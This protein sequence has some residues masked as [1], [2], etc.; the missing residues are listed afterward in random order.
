MLYV[1]VKVTE[2]C[3]F[4]CKYCYFFCSKDN[5]FLQ[6]PPFMDFDTV[7]CLANF[8]KQGVMDLKLKHIHICIHGGEP[9]LY[10]TDNID[11]FCS[12]ILDTISPYAEICFSIQTNGYL[13][14]DIWLDLFEKYNMFVGVS[15]DGPSEYHD[16]FR[17]DAVG[18]KTHPV[19]ENNLKKLLKRKRLYD[20]K[21]IGILTV[22]DPTHSPEKLYKY[23]VHKLEVQVMDF[24]L[25]DHHYDHKPPYLPESYGNFLIELYKQWMKDDD[26][27]IR[28]KFFEAVLASIL[29]YKSTLIG[30]GPFVPNR[31]PVIT[32]SSDGS[33]RAVDELCKAVPRLISKNVY[34][35]NITCK[36]F[37][38]SSV[39]K[40]I[41]DAQ[42][43][44]PDE[45]INCTHNNTCSAGYILNRYSKKNFFNNPSIYCAGLKKFYDHVVE[46][47]KTHQ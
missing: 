1:I 6:H 36:K 24:L 16:K 33:L 2:I 45:C 22:I 13:I 44:L 27:D 17:V 31:L 21:N 28:I 42:M 18:R 46:H 15:L 34:L 10:G 43:N 20:K 11:K 25:P 12:H 39:F 4:K 7:K 29:G 35:D 19:V 41:A 8:I 38:T 9:L 30:I 37:I 47:V 26:P 40:D 23:F 32:V 3:I 14:S 5:S